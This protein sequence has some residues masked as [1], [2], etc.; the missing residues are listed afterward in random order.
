MD[1][2]ELILNKDGSVY[3]LKLKPENLSSTV[4]LVGD[5]FRVDKVTKHFNK[6][7]FKTQNPGK[8]WEKHYTQHLLREDLIKLLTF[9]NETENVGAT[10]QKTWMGAI[11]P[12][13]LLL[14]LFFGRYP[15]KNG[16]NSHN[17]FNSY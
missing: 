14:T 3:H 7:E 15:H 2:S 11:G 6:I 1:R 17:E 16:T 9:N 5:P 13:Q 4:I 8:N 10:L 12:S